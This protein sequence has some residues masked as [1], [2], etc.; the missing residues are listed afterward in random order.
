M[1]I[2]TKKLSFTL[3]ILT[4]ALA[5]AQG[6][7]TQ[8][9]SAAIS[10]LVNV[11][12]TGIPT[13]GAFSTSA[14]IEAGLVSDPVDF[15]VKSNR[16]WTISTAITSI[17]GTPISGGPTTISAPL[18]PQNISWGVLNGSAQTISTF[19]PFGSTV[20]TATEIKTG[21]R[22]APAVTGN[23]FT[24][25]YKVTPGYLVDPGSYAIVVT[26]TISAQ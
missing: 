15:A 8:N 19:T 20:N 26:H 6:T 16:L 7:S 2:T 12:V 18:P 10:S 11:N 9:F 23:T 14:D 13:I 1:K 21:A 25:R 5:N 3:L 4:V 17:T 22:G 24:L